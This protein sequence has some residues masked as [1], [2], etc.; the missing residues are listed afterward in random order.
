MDKGSN[1]HIPSSVSGHH[2]AKERPNSVVMERRNENSGST[3]SAKDISPSPLVQIVVY[4]IDI[5]AK[6][7]PRELLKL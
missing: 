3:T 5:T 6:T 4:V 2:E 1:G 7:K